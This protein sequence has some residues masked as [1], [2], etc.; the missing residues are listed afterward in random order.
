MTF[1]NNLVSGKPGMILG[2]FIRF[3]FTES[4]P[5]LLKCHENHRT[6]DIVTIGTAWGNLKRFS[7]LPRTRFE[8]CRILLESFNKRRTIVYLRRKNSATGYLVQPKL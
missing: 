4:K 5:K 8:S 2:K 1:I 7:K 3:A 6:Y